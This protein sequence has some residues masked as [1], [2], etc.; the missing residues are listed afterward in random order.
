MVV[1][2]PLAG[3]AVAA[4]PPAAVVLLAA[5]AAVAVLLA[6]PVVAAALL[7]GLPPQLARRS[8]L[9]TQQ[10][11][12]DA[13]PPRARRPNAQA[14]AQSHPAEVRCCLRFKVSCACPEPVLANIRFVSSNGIARKKFP[15]PHQVMLVLVVL[16]PAPANIGVKTAIRVS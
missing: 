6:A 13:P 1:A 3:L 12:G 7:G 8:I 4:A 5:P 11:P 9:V 10:R 14:R 16:V 2:A 15:P